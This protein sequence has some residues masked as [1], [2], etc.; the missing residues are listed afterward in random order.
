MVARKFSSLHSTYAPCTLRVLTFKFILGGFSTVRFI[1][2]LP[3][4]HHHGIKTLAKCEMTRHVTSY[5]MRFSVNESTLGVRICQI[6][7]YPLARTSCKTG[8]CSP[9]EPSNGY[10][11][12]L[13]GLTAGNI[14]IHWPELFALVGSSSPLAPTNGY[15]NPYPPGSIDAST[16]EPRGPIKPS[17]FIAPISMFIYKLAHPVKPSTSDLPFCD[18]WWTH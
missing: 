6:T 9:P 1:Y 4:Y 11:P 13:S 7:I 14:Y 15:Y 16:A 8:P 12:Y 2:H 5:L 10:N 17:D 18:T 3:W